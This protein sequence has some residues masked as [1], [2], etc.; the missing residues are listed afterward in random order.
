MLDLK[1]LELDLL[2][3]QAAGTGRL[4]DD[5]APPNL[6]LMRCCWIWISWNC[7]MP[8]VLVQGARAGDGSLAGQ[9]RAGAPQAGAD[10]AGERGV[11]PA[12]ALQVLPRPSGRAGQGFTF[13]RPHT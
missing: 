11:G 1:L 10:P 2:K 5:D 12:S 8:R 7:P 6:E 13:T 3:C 4:G 9:E